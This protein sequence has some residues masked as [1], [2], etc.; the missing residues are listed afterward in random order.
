MIL[1]GLYNPAGLVHIPKTKY[2]GLQIRIIKTIVYENAIDD[3]NW[4][5][6]SRT[7]KPNFPMVVKQVS[8]L[9]GDYYLVPYVSV[10]DQQSVYYDLDSYTDYF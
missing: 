10:E 4:E 9:F 5:R 7:L 6:D 8:R 3:Y 1:L 2:T